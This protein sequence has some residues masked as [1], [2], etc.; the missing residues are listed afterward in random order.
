[1]VQDLL[2]VLL[3]DESLLNLKLLVLL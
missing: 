1:M 2:L 3:M